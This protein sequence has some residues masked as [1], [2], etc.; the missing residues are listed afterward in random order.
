[1][2][3]Y[4]LFQEWLKLSKEKEKIISDPLLLQK[5]QD[6]EKHVSKYLNVFKNYP[7]I[8]NLGHGV[9][10]ETKPETIL[11]IIKIIKNKK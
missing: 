11:E 8:F 4:I 6:I 2:N 3:F 1:M 5:N 9:L 10:P 7:Y